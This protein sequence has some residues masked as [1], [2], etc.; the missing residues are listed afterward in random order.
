MQSGDYTNAFV[1][2]RWENMH[3]INDTTNWRI[4][5]LDWKTVNAVSGAILTNIENDYDAYGRLSKAKV[6]LGS[7]WAVT[8]FTYDNWGNVIQVVDPRGN[9]TSTEYNGVPGLNLLPSKVTNALGH[10]STTTY[11]PVLLLPRTI[12]SPNNAVTDTQYDVL[13]RVL[14]NQQYPSG[15]PA[16][17]E[18]DITYAYRDAVLNGDVLTRAFRTQATART[19]KLDASKTVTGYFHYN[20]MGRLIQEEMPASVS[21]KGI[22]KNYRY[23]PS[24]QV[25]WDYNPALF[26]DDDGGSV[27]DG[28]SFIPGAYIQAL[29]DTFLVGAFRSFDALGRLT[30]VVRKEYNSAARPVLSEHAYLPWKTLTRDANGSQI[31]HEKDE[32]GL[33]VRAYQSLAFS[34]ILSWFPHGCTGSLKCTQYGYDGRGLLTS[35]RD[36]EGNVGTRT[37]DL[38]SRM[39]SMTDPDLG[40]WNYTYDA[41]GNLITSTDAR[42]QRVE[43]QYDRIDRLTT[44]QWQEAGSQTWRSVK[45]TYDTGTN[46]RG[47]RT[48]LYDNTCDAQVR[49]G[50][51]CTTWAYDIYG[52]LLGET[53]KTFNP[54]GSADETFYT[55]FVYDM[56]GRPTT[57]RYPYRTGESRESVTTTYNGQGLVSSLKGSTNTYLSSSLFNASGQPTSLTLGN[58]LTRSSTYNLNTGRPERLQAGILQDSA[59]TYDPAGNILSVRDATNG[60]QTESFGYDALGRLDWAQTSGGGYSPYSIDYA[61]NNLGNLT[62]VAWKIPSTPPA[63]HASGWLAY[64]AAGQ[65]RPHAVTST[66]NGFGYLYDANGNMIARSEGSTD[67]IHTFNELNLLTQVE[68]SQ[69]PTFIDNFNVLDVSQWAS[70][71]G[72]DSIEN[73]MLVHSGGCPPLNRTAYTIEGAAVGEGIKLEFSAAHTETDE[74]ECFCKDKYCY[75]QCFTRGVNTLPAHTLELKAST[76]PYRFGLQAGPDAL[77]IAYDTGGGLAYLSLSEVPYQVGATY[78]LSLSIQ[79]SGAATA[80]VWR[81][82]SPQTRALRKLSLPAGLAYRFTLTSGGTQLT[83]K[84]YLDNYLEQP[85]S[86]NEFTYDGDAKRIKMVTTD[87]AGAVTTTY[88]PTRFYEQTLTSKMT[89][90]RFYYFASEAPLAVRV[91]DLT[92][93]NNLY[94]YLPDHLGSRRVLAV[95]QNVAAEVTRYYPFGGDRTPPGTTSL[96]SMHFTGQ[97]LDPTGLHYYN[98]RYYAAGI[99]R[100]ISPDPLLHS[101]AFPQNL[102]LYTYTRNN[103]LNYF[104]PT[105]QDGV[106]ALAFITGV[107]WGWT[108][109]N[110]WLFPGYQAWVDS[111]APTNSTE[112]VAG[113][114]VGDLLAMGTSGALFGGGTGMGGAGAF[115]CAGTGG[116]FVPGC[117]A[118]VGGA[119]LVA[120]ATG[121]GLTAAVDAGIQGAKLLAAET[122][123]GNGGNGQGPDVDHLRLPKKR[124]VAPQ[125]RDGSVDMWTD[126]EYRWAFDNYFKLSHGDLKHRMDLLKVILPRD[127]VKIVYIIRT[128]YRDVD[129]ITQEEWVELRMVEAI[130]N[131][132]NAADG[133]PGVGPFPLPPR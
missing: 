64:P 76:A 133:Y 93:Q 102:N 11:D 34:S 38:G 121:A 1:M 49:S 3:Y 23:H 58:G 26:P 39:T 66:Q 55:N 113:R 50:T 22:V 101:P 44:K 10:F 131:A 123:D 14:R 108:R 100:F 13:G 83:D 69:N 5:M 48:A 106:S 52:K 35:I 109:S 105:G 75:D 78:V 119:I 33:L 7:T 21:G 31:I 43:L 67:S 42:R 51:A 99:G 20:G 132:M 71:V 111:K 56:L 122:G 32:N 8:E 120:Q 90:Q 126:A 128:A 85:Y 82:D 54:S 46:Q 72:C 53:K 40:T 17:L 96:T 6:N 95:Q 129:D 112:Y 27:Y 92:G 80:Q 97:R 63:A 88:Y 15:N 12:T 130:I 16:A 116:V 74:E 9:S 87:A 60:G 47:L 30:K 70:V 77:W 89:T 37:Y 117:V 57:V 4:G 29:D 73:G 103:P 125:G 68:Q 81:K 107:V 115:A 118:T 104:D 86:K 62:N 91:K 124:H 114:L 94:Y 19:D 18:S 25:W 41:N 65:A 127:R 84:V 45:H 98:A 59:Y 2:S 79:P 24:G 28:G 61:Y 36:E 110:L